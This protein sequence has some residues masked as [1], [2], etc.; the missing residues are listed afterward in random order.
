M[1]DKRMLTFDYNLIPYEEKNNWNPTYTGCK[2]PWKPEKKNEKI[3]LIFEII[4]N[5]FAKLLL[6]YKNININKN[7]KKNCHKERR[8][9]IQT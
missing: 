6:L 5:L 9:H 1:V 3:H 2:T 8:Y 7:E 4:V